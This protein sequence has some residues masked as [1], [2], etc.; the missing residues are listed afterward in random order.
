M[1][2]YYRESWLVIVIFLYCG[3][4]FFLDAQAPWESLFNGVDLTGWTPK[5]SGYPAGENYKHTFVVADSVLKVSYAEYDT[6]RNEFGHLFYQ[7]SYS[8]FRLRLEYRFTGH[9]TPGAP[10]WGVRNNGIM[11]FAQSAQ[12]MGLNQDFPVSVEVQLLG[13]NGTGERPTCNVCTPGTHIYMHDSLMTT[14]CI[15]ST[16]P[17]FPD[18]RWVH[19]EVD[20]MPDGMIYHICDG[21][22]VM[23]YSDPIIGGDFLPKNYPVKEGQRLTQG[24]IALQA[25]S[26]PT[27]FRHIMIQPIT[28]Q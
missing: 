20:V 23:R 19:V 1:K 13:D 6:F 16:A 11:I 4:S 7:T 21:D 14:H 22:T 25:E 28:K 5:F 24:Y 18:N 12:S 27:E 8:A 15:N 9:S 17:T 3:Q 2:R 10:A 26:H